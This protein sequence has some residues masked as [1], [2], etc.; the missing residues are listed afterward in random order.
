MAHMLGEDVLPEEVQSRR[1]RLRNRIRS[2]R[3]PVR[4]RRENM[5]P[6]PDVVGKLE[7]QVM[8]LRNKAMNR[9]GVLGRIRGD[10]SGSGGSSGSSNGGTSESS[11]TSSMT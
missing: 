11:S 3:E 1:R 9:D 7:N 10:S 8:S 4:S 2:L 5:V 6:G